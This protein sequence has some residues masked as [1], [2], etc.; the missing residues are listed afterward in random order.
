MWKAYGHL[1]IRENK[2][3]RKNAKQAQFAELSGS[4]ILE[5]RARENACAHAN[6]ARNCDISGA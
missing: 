4:K 2:H 3:G 6:I 5:K 1:L